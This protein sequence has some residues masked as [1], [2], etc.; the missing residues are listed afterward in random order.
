M[1]ILI[2]A[3]VSTGLAQTISTHE[4]FIDS[5]QQAELQPLSFLSVKGNKIINE[6]RE[7]IMLRGFQF[8]CFYMFNKRKYK[9]IKL[10]GE[11]PDKYN[12]ELSNYYCTNN[13]IKNIKN[14]G[15]NV[16][17]IAFRLWHI[18]KEPYSYNEKSLKHLDNI[19]DRFGENGIYVILDLHSA[20][21]NSF[22]HNQLYGNIL[23]DDKD[24]QDRVIALWGLIANRYKDNPSI[25]GYDIINEPQAPTKKALH[26]FYQK[27]IK[28]IRETDKK[29]ILFIEW[30]HHDLENILFGG[31][32]DDPNIA[33]SL[34][35][36]KPNK[37]TNQGRRGRPIGYK[38]PAKYK[39]IYWDKNQI[40]KYFTE[41]L[42]TKIKDKPLF[43][44]E[45]SATVLAGGEYALQWIKDVIDVMNS[46]GVHY[47]YFQYK[48]VNRE[49]FSYYWAHKEV[50]EKIMMLMKNI[51]RNRLKFSDLT[52]GKKKLIL[53]KN[54]E[55]SKKLKQVLK[56][57][58]AD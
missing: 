33:M 22:Y 36:Y 52:E 38:Y 30:N 44:G 32:Y 19:I 1:L 47:T 12:I 26:S 28:K 25:A 10:S 4:H 20:G 56:E 8:D 43:V 18:E 2:V 39:G 15:A 50:S 55:S 11:D 49:Q 37:F 16:V 3:F 13:D 27:S 7:E 42:R 58:F 23:W 46:K 57:G 41:V 45:F 31:E 51:V 53:T 6:K 9:A 48:C 24:F 17:R 14:M 29:H 54:F 35:F 5:H 21:Q 40:D 34:H